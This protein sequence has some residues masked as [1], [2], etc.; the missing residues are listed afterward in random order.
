MPTVFVGHYGHPLL[1]GAKH[2]SFLLPVENQL[3][4][5]MAYQVT[6]STDTYRVKDLEVVVL[7]DSQSFMGMIEVG[8]IEESQW[9]EFEIVVSSVPAT[10]GNKA[11][12]CQNWI[13]EVLAAAKAKGM[14]VEAHSLMELQVLLASASN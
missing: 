8:H 11:W 10:R 2:W 1:A 4:Q 14:S 13:I 9:Q 7:E 12:N 6:G 3:K 5:Y